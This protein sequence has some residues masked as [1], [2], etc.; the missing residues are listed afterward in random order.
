MPRLS[1]MF[2]LVATVL[3][4]ACAA[5]TETSRNAV[6][7]SVG[8]LVSPQGFVFLP[9]KAS[10]E[11]FA[12]RPAS[13]DVRSIKVLVPRTLKVS[14]A[15]RYLPAGDIVWREDPLGDRYA[16]VQKIF[17]DALATGT[18]NVEGDTPVALYVQ[19][20]RFHALT[21]KARYTTGGVH[22]IKFGYAL[23]NLQTG[24]WLGK[25]RVVEADLNALGG[26]AA[27]ASERRGESQKSRISTHLAQVIYEEL[28]VEQGHKNARLGVIQQLN[29]F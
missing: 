12:P 14:E 18:K 28:S 26:H 7:P 25:P 17:E 19:V 1:A 2:A 5:P 21:E 6:A 23:K 10:D 27:L 3:L 20:M 13:V 15:N 11:P 24:E 4:S 29:K 9:A 8:D 16:Q 22:S